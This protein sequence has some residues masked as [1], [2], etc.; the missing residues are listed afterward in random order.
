MICT[1]RWQAAWAK[2]PSAVVSTS[3][4]AQA[5]EQTEMDEDEEDAVLEEEQNEMFF[6]NIE[7]EFEWMV[8]ENQESNW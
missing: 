7:A 4:I 1:R 2:A 6:D 3:A 5:A 8:Q